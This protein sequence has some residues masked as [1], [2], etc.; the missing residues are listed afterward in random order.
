MKKALEMAKIAYDMGEVPVGAVVVKKSNG[1]I[2]GQGYNRRETDKSSIAHAEIIAINMASKNLG[3]WRLVD[4]EIY[5]TLEPCLMCAGAILNSR[6]ERVVFGANDINRGYRKA[7]GNLFGLQNAYNIP[8][9]SGVL[10][11]DCS[12]IISDF[13]RNLR[14]K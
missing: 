5:V 8:V 7:V 1:E 6:L 9:T 3:G 11:E 2:V 4:C 13:F 14:K 12:G 10:L